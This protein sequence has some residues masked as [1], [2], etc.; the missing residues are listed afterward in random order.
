M[1][2][3]LSSN[4]IVFKNITAFYCLNQAISDKFFFWLYPGEQI[5][6]TETDFASSELM[7]PELSPR[8]QQQ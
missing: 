6:Y 2:L 1:P 4:V 7:H 3:Q 5:T 8:N